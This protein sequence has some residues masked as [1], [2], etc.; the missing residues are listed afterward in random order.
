MPF[1]PNRL[2]NTSFSSQTQQCATH[3]GGHEIDRVEYGDGPAWPDEPGRSV[4]L[5]RRAWGSSS[6]AIPDA[7]C[8]GASPMSGGDMGTPGTWNDVCGG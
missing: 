4:S 7:W 1:D 3:P 8:P 6:A 2:V 5:S